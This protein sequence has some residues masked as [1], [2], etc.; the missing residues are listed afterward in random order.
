MRQLGLDLR[1]SKNIFHGLSKDEQREVLFSVL[2]EAGG[3]R[4]KAATILDCTYKSIE[5]Y[6][7]KL[8][9]SK[10]LAKALEIDNEER[11]S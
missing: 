6:I 11:N 7:Y 3:D 4:K 9:L 5:K 10:P 8:N 2:I 1:E